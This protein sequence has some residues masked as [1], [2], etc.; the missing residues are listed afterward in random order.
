M[1]RE[2]AKSK[3]LALA[4]TV[5]WTAAVKPGILSDTVRVEILSP[6]GN[7]IFAGT[8]LDSREDDEIWEDALCDLDG[9]P[10]RDGDETDWPALFGD[11]SFTRSRIYPDYAKSA[12]ELFVRIAM[13]GIA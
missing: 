3:I 12:E 11:F 10:R 8:G 13:A 7:K 9:R 2:S 4:R 1:E 5:G 6:G